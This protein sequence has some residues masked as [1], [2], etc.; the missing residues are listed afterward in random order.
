MKPEEILAHVRQLIQEHASNDPDEW[1]YANRYVFARLNLDER[2][3]K[4]DLTIGLTHH[5]NGSSK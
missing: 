2:K 5:T 1:W 4:T 3:T